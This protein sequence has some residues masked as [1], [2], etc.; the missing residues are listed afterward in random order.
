MPTMYFGD[1]KQDIDFGALADQIADSD[2][3]SANPAPLPS[4]KQRSVG[5]YSVKE[6]TPSIAEPAFPDTTQ[7]P[8]YDFWGNLKTLIGGDDGVSDEELGYLR[9]LFE[10]DPKWKPPASAK[11]QRLMKM[12]QTFKTLGYDSDLMSIV[13]ALF[14]MGYS[15]PAFSL[16]LFNRLLAPYG[17]STAQPTTTATTK[18]KKAS[19]ATSDIEAMLAQL[20]L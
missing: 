17:L 15:Q 4:Y 3:P 5:V 7:K 9:E 13:G 11:A 6:S 2:V 18:S 16:S 14:D 1:Q 20:G 12:A 19:S 8:A 10:A